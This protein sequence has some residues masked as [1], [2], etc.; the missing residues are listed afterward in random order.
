MALATVPDATLSGPFSIASSNLVVGQNVLA[1]EL[2]QTTAQTNAGLRISRGLGLQGHLGWRRRRLFL[3]GSPALAPTNAALA[4]LG[5]EVFTSSNTNLAANVNDGRYGS[6]SAW[7]PAASD[8]APYVILR[9]NQT[10]PV[11]SIAWSR[12]NGD[13]NE[14]GLRRHL[15]RPCPRQ[16][17]LPVHAGHQPRR[18]HRQ[19]QQSFQRLDHHRHGAV[20]QRPAGLH[21]APAAPFRIRRHERQSDPGHW[22]PAPHAAVSNT[23]G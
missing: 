20:S 14:A 2:H 1:V 21:A 8:P 7:T 13:T 16:L 10:L 11:S 18:R 5:V 6:S 9:F 19:L 15:H 22:R 4:S 17:H 3:A 12:D 23:R